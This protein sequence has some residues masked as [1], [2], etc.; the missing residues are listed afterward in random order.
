MPQTISLLATKSPAPPAQPGPLISLVSPSPEPQASYPTL[1]PVAG[2]AFVAIPE[3]RAPLASI[4]ATPI[5]S[6]GAWPV[7]FITSR[8][9]NSAE[10][11]HAPPG[12]TPMPSTTI[13]IQTQNGCSAQA[14]PSHPRP[15]KKRVKAGSLNA[16]AQPASSQTA[17]KST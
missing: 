8:M 9:K 12:V 15:A 3:A 5:Y 1:T 17:I 6:P 11:E 2:P 10:A 4:P 16:K 14:L 7:H 13:T